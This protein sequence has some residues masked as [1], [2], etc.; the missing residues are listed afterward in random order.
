MS[1]LIN[2]PTVE[3]IDH[4]GKGQA[5]PLWAAKKLIY[6]K[7]TRLEQ[8]QDTWAKIH[9]MNQ[10]EVQEQ[11]DYV[12]DSVRSSW[13]FVSFTFQIKNVTRG[14]THQF[15]RTRTASYAQQSQRVVDM[16]GFDFGCGPV[17]AGDPEMLGEYK[18]CMGEINSAYEKLIS[19]GAPA[20]DARGLLPTA[21]STSIIAEINLRTLADLAIKRDNPRAEGEYHKVFKGIAEAAIEAMPWVEDFLYPER[22]S[23]PNLDKLLIEMR[24]DRS[25]VEMNE[26]N[27]AMKELDKL[28]KAW[29]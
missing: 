5:D 21:V 23:T 11:L 3:V 14:F 20:Q 9:S 17:V 25:P 2:T 28:K 18:A 29:G 27:S 8:G 10:E 1:N 26:L 6:T 16:S 13:E 24:G 12:R 19:L 4:T 15:V 7:L 22:T